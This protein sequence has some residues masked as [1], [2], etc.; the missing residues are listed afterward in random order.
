M[1]GLCHNCNEV[2][3][4]SRCRVAT[5]CTKECQTQIPRASCHLRALLNG[6]SYSSI[7]SSI[8]RWGD[9]LYHYSIVGLILQT[10]RPDILMHTGKQRPRTNLGLLNSVVMSDSMLR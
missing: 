9:L 10:I 5:Y 1:S 4:C 6:M 2:K 3:R 8:A 7:K